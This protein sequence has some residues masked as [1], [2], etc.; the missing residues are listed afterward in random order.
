MQ[1][2][3][4]PTLLDVRDRGAGDANRRCQLPLAHLSRLA[5][6][7][8]AGNRLP[9]LFV[10]GGWRSRSHEGS[11]AHWPCAVKFIN[12]VCNPVIQVLTYLTDRFRCTTLPLGLPTTGS[13]PNPNCPDQKGNTPMATEPNEAARPHIVH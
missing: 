8:K 13:A 3:P 5:F 6:Q 12:R 10:D 11:L 4:V 1:L 9:D 7:A 2:D